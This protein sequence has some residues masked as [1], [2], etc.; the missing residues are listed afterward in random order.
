M[1]IE[2]EEIYDDEVVEREIDLSKTYSLPREICI[3]EYKNVYLAIYT[4]GVLW[5]VLQNDEELTIFNLIRNGVNLENLFE[6]YSEEAVLNVVM[7]IEAKK[8][9]SPRI[10]EFD[11]KTVYIY[12][13]NNCNQRCRHCYMYAGDIKVEEVNFEKW[14]PVLNTLAEAGCEGVTFTGGEVT[15]YKGF[16]KLVEYAHNIGLA[17]TVLSNGI[18]WNEKMVESL[19]PFIDEIQISIDGYDAKSYYSVRKY[20]GFDKAMNCIEL[21][22]NT[23]TKVSM[24]V[25]PLFE[26]LDLFIDKFEPFA[27]DFLNTHPNVFIKL[28]HELIMGR[29]VKTTDEENREYRTKLKKLVERLYPEYYTETFVLNYEN[30]ALRRN[31]GFGGISIA[32]NGDIYW[33]NQIHELNSTMNVFK[34]DM[35]TI[36]E[37]SKW[38]KE[39]TSVD[40]TAGCMNCAVKYICGGECRMKYE[41]IQNVENHLGLWDCKCGGKEHLYEKMIRSN[42]YFFEG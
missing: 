31:C 20:D 37:K 40:N 16:G 34:C 26:N 35:N 30:K 5:I 33:C 17:V 1:T 4:K 28:N 8:F 29:E 2:N 41:G 9:D 6:N 23:G 3:V 13:T 32:A 14:I 22:S 39:N 19:S 10:N 11:E 15:V 21:F 42:E 38:V 25:T 27:K 24:A 12:L 36:F 7:Q 18:L